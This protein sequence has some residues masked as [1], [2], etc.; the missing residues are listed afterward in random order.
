MAKS[1]YQGSKS[2]TVI[3]IFTEEPSAKK[4][5]DHILPKLLPENTSFRVY[6]HQGKQDLEKALRDS[7]P[8]I[9]K[10]PGSKI[11]ITRD[12]D[13][14]DCVLVKKTIKERIDFNCNCDYKIRIVCRELESWFL[15]DLK[16]IKKAYPRFSPEH[17]QHKADIRNVDNIVSPNKYL[18]KIIP[19]F[20]SQTTL[21]KLEVADSI[22]PHLGIESNQSKS[23]NQMVNAIKELLNS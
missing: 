23:F 2:M 13:N 5:F 1:L 9:S 17:Y 22:A 15:G 14:D 8:S 20:K 19:E 12:Q 6:P 10:M 11:L 18:L 7:V 16:A 21:P 3:H 4:V